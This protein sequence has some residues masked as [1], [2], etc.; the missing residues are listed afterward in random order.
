MNGF[1][2]DSM[3]DAATRLIRTIRNKSLHDKARK[4]YDM[5][6]D[7]N[8]RIMETYF[9]MLQKGEIDSYV[10]E[11][12]NQ[13][14]VRSMNIYHRSP[15]APGCVQKSIAMIKNGEFIPLMDS[16]YSC[17][18]DLKD[19]GFSSGYYYIHQNSNGKEAA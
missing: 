15:K 12:T 2:I 4:E 3:S 11:H 1:Y 5:L 14:G 13:F 9:N 17:I 7:R 8:D 16:Q 6:S 19:D 18:E 10:H